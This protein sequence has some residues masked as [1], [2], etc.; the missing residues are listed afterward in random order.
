MHR[1]PL[2]TVLCSAAHSNSW[3]QMYGHTFSESNLLSQI[4]DTGLKRL[5]LSLQRRAVVRHGGD[6]AL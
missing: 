3:R 5:Q 4:N 6:L 1:A 2:F